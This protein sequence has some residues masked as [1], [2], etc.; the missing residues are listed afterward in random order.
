ML[1]DDQYSLP[2]TLCYFK[3]FDMH[4][5]W[6]KHKYDDYYNTLCFCFA[7]NTIKFWHF[8]KSWIFVIPISY[9]YYFLKW[10]RPLLLKNK[11]DLNSWYDRWRS[12]K[13][14][15]HKDELIIIVVNLTETLLVFYFSILTILTKTSLECFTWF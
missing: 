13:Y 6:T 12:T 10:S 2:A 15:S 8:N 4:R 5:Q 1:F 9:L 14:K 7:E 3:L 11:D